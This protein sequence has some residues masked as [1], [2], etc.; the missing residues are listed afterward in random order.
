MS[1]NTGRASVAKA[2]GGLTFSNDKASDRVAS[3]S[4]LKVSVASLKDQRDIVDH[5][6]LPNILQRSELVDEARPRASN[7]F[8]VERVTNMAGHRVPYRRDL[9]TSKVVRNL[10]WSHD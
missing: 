6:G 7:G 1:R 8:L 2:A 9:A 4:H 3:V 10:C 5:H